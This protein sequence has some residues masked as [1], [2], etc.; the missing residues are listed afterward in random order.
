[1]RSG[2]VLL[3]TDVWSHLFGFKVRHP[4]EATWRSLL[5]GKTVAVAAQTRAEVLA[6]VRIRQ[7]GEAR[8]SRIVQQLDD[9][10][11]VPVDE[12]VIQRFA[13]L[14]ADA[15]ARG[16]AL[17]DKAHT[18]DRWI[19]ATALRVDAALL[20]ADRIF[21]NDPDLTLLDSETP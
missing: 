18:G 8:A 21:R 10:A 1:M 11:T 6:W 4:Q 16:D 13:R 9:T 15:R 19:A 7:L 3:D 20:M 5:T 14:T 2:V 12:A 17:A